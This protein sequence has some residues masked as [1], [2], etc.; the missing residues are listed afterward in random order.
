MVPILNT[1]SPNNSVRANNYVEVRGSSVSDITIYPFNGYIL[2]PFPK[3][4]NLIISV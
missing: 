1:L 2:P 4:P 3:C